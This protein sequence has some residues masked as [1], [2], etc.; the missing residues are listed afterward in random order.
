VHALNCRY[1]NS[2]T[3]RSA[4]LLTQVKN[5][6]AKSGSFDRKWT[7]ACAVILSASLLGWLIYTSQKPSI[8]HYLQAHGYADEDFARQIIAFSIGQAGWWLVI[9]AASISLLTLIISGYFAGSRTK[10]AGL[11]LGGLLVFDLGRA[12]LPFVIHWDYKQ[13]YEVGALNPVEE[14]LQ[15]KPYEH[16]V[17]GLPFETQQQLRSYNNAFGGSGIYRIEWTQHHFLYYNIQSLDVIQMSRTSEDL[18]SYLGRCF[19]TRPPMHRNMPA[20]GS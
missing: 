9:F 16:R 18:K 6:W 4:D 2:A 11:F 12:D 7:L 5:W 10:L 8:V 19:H 20:T 1:L 14:F 17:A 13:K 3:P 15:D